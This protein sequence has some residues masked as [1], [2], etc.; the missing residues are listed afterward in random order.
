[1]NLRIVPYQPSE[2]A[3]G[4]VLI[5]AALLAYAGAVVTLVLVRGRDIDA[6]PAVEAV[7]GDGHV[8]DPGRSRVGNA[9]GQ[10]GH[11]A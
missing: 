3:K 8:R 7:L 1:M 6:G 4:I 10:D 2:R 11:V 9:P 5:G